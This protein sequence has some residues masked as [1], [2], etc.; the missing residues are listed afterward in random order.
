ML[1]FLSVN[2][3]VIAPANTGNDNNNKNAVIKTAH[4]NNGKLWKDRLFTRILKIVQIK[5]IAPKIEDAP[6]KCKLKIAKSTEPP[7]CAVALD[8]GG[9]TVQPVPTPASVNIDAN[10][11]SNEGGN[12]QKLMLFILGKAIS[13][14]PIIK[15]TNQLPNP[16]IKVGITMKKIIN[17]AWPVTITLYRWWLYSKK[18]PLGCANVI[19]IYKDKAVPATPEMAPKIKYKVPISL[20]LVEKS[21]RVTN[22]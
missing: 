12:N 4:T 3:I 16:P 13:G 1:K 20:W 2:N 5:L 7:E 15:G 6:D 14:A 10:N 21:Q 19:R 9:Y 22:L 8:S 17:I 11:N 18:L